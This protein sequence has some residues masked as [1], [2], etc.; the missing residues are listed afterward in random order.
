M[1]AWRIYAV[2]D[3]PLKT[4]SLETLLLQESDL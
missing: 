3:D 4:R 2:D 1:A